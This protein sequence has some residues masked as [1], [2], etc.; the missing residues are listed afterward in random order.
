M[1]WASRTDT[2]INMHLCSSSSSSV[3]AREYCLLVHAP[4][5]LVGVSCLGTADVKQDSHRMRKQAS[6]YLQQD[7]FKYTNDNSPAMYPAFPVFEQLWG[8]TQGLYRHARA[9]QAHK[10]CRQVHKGC[11]QRTSAVSSCGPGKCAYAVAST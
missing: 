9:M 11:G 8:S 2:G 10:G 6:G 5:L 7:G 1:E 4:R 3:Y